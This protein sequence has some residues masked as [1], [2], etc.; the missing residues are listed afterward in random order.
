MPEL[1][2]KHGWDWVDRTRKEQKKLNNNTTFSY[3]HEDG[4]CK[5]YD[6]KS[7]ERCLRYHIIPTYH[8]SE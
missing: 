6:D 8:S 2:V 5:I 4:R 1:Y 3:T 7:I